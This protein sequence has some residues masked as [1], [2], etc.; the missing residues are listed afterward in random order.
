M[1]LINNKNISIN[2]LYIQLFMQKTM[3]EAVF[4]QIQKDNNA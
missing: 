1:Q 2:N 3:E 4:L